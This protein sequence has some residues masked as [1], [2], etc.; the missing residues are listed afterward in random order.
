[1]FRFEGSRVESLAEL[2]RH[3]SVIYLHT[4]SKTLCPSIRVGAAVVP[5]A[6]F[7]DAESSRRLVN[8]LSER[9]SYLA[10]NTSQINQAMVAGILLTE[11]F[12]LETT[13][14]RAR[15]FYR[16]NRDILTEELRAGLGAH[17][18]RVHWNRPEGGFFLVVQLPFAFGSEE[19]LTCAN[20]Y[21]VVVMP[22]SFFSLTNGHRS[23][24]RLAYSNLDPS[25][26]SVGAHR[27]ARFILDRIGAN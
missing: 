1:M 9:K 24:V 23:T 17:A 16:R 10:V 18:R 2:D 7:G 27:L 15:D 13:V 12:T 21:S 20:D 19:M 14:S 3:G 11:Q 5:A 22:M 4:F 8:A 6:L 26:L 25:Q